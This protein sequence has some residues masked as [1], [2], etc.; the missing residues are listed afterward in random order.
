M[1]R[2]RKR[3]VPPS[4]HELEAEVM[5]EVW[6]H[7]EISVRALMEI[8]N[9]RA[10]KPR[11]YTTYMTIMAR[12]DGKGLLKR[13]REGKADHYSGVFSRDEYRELR[14]QS[15]VQ[16]LVSEFGDVAL[17]HFAR[18]MNELDPDRLR[19]LR[20]IARRSE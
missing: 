7:D 11:A 20:R 10:S 16:A 14:A 3:P 12:L 1:A 5:E 6:Q 17:A 19:Q 8:L 13:R 15:E 18:Q 2:L 9:G 4:L